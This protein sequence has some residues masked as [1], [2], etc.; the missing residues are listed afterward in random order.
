[1]IETYQKTP[2]KEL[3][4][5][6]ESGDCLV[7]AKA[8]V[9][10][11]ALFMQ[12]TDTSKLYQEKIIQSWFESRSTY[13]FPFTYTNHREFFEALKGLDVPYQIAGLHVY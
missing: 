12:K 2:P 13:P 4:F 1:L 7:R 3:I 9:I 5:M 6:L 11:R 10:I 8:D